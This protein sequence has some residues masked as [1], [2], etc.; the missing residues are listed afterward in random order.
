MTTEQVVSGSNAII[1][2]PVFSPI[3]HNGRQ[4]V[5]NNV[6]ICSVWP[7]DLSSWKLHGGRNQLYRIPAVEKGKYALLKV[8]DTYTVTR[9]IAVES[10]GP[11]AYQNSPISCL[12]VA[13]N[14]LKEW[15]E[16]AP[17]NASGA[18]PGIMIIAGDTPTQTELDAM[19]ASQTE[20]FRWLVKRADDYWIQGKREYISSD[21]RRAL[22]WL[23]SEDRDWFQEI[24]E[25]LKKRCY[26]CA[27]EINTDAIVC[28][29][30]STN[31]VDFCI[32]QGVIPPAEDA[33][34]TKGIARKRAKK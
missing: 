18:R 30:C 19:W 32:D 20:Y 33:A 26:A 9:N 24:A 21:H 16:D 31:L 3:P 11:E 25:V 27:E 14:L 1:A 29:H 23:G 10:E 2:E 6:T 28:K 8:Y 7:D 22:R 4:Y 17:G 34:V 13:E 15:A 12:G 5:P